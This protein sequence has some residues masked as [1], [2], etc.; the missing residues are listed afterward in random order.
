MRAKELQAV[1]GSME[2]A[3]GAGLPVVVH[4]VE[5]TKAVVRREE[6]ATRGKEVMVVAGLEVVVKGVV[7]WVGVDALGVTMVVAVM[8]SVTLGEV[9]KAQEM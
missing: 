1:M 3:V 2:A 4:L 9:E 5:A 7:V 6:E 8:G